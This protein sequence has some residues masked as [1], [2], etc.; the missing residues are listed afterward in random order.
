MTY[1]FLTIILIISGCSDMNEGHQG[2]VIER[3]IKIQNRSCVVVSENFDTTWR[4]G[5]PEIKVTG[6]ESVVKNVITEHSNHCLYISMKA[7]SGDYN[8]RIPLNI[9]SSN[10]SYFSATGFSKFDIKLMDEKKIAIEL[11]GNAQGSIGGIV[12]Q[13]YIYT[14][15]ES[16]I[17]AKNLEAKIV[18]IY[19]TGDTKISVNPI[20]IMDI[21]A[22]GSSE[23][24]YLGDPK[25]NKNISKNIKLKKL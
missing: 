5:L 20:E 12:D 14:H 1:L 9:K 17:N 7:D 6:P 13:V 15:N 4:Y 23:I 16:D 8:H 10:L 21:K 25:I 19:S 22:T 18:K 2:E 11:S 24:Y 3:Y